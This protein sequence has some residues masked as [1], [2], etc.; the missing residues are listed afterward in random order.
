MPKRDQLHQCSQG[1]WQKVTVF[2][3]YWMKKRHKI[4]FFSFMLNNRCWFVFCA[5]FIRSIGH[6]GGQQ[7]WVPHVNYK[8]GAHFFDRNLSIIEIENVKE[9]YQYLSLETFLG[10]K[11]IY[12]N[13]FENF[14][15]LLKIDDDKCII[16]YWNLRGL[17]LNLKI[18]FN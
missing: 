11:Y 9:S 15:W 16:M 10:F 18:F 8:F 6:R 3:K 13:S 7:K 12:E 17:S 4:H 5:F 2:K 14:K 1:K